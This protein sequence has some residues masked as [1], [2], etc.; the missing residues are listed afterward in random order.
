MELARIIEGMVGR[1]VSAIIANNTAPTREVAAA[2]GAEQKYPILPTES[3]HA[4][5]RL[6][7]ARLWSDVSI[8]RHDSARLASVVTFL[9]SKLLGRSKL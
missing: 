8:A 9:I 7:T 2:Y 4:D 3:D 1:K 5:P 6:C